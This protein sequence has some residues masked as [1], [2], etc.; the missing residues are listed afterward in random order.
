MNQTIAIVV[1]VILL[2][3]G[4]EQYGEHRIQ[5]KW[6][7]DKAARAAVTERDKQENAKNLADLK[8][9][10]EKEKKDAESEAGRRAVA[11]YLRDYGLLPSS[12]PVRIGDSHQADIPQRADTTSGE[13]GLA[14]RITE[15]AGRCIDDARKVE[16]CAEWAARENLPVE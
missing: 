7:E 11:K 5:V 1:A 4:V 8:E 13:S 12:I 2:L 10:F 15:L 3:I 14:E 6:N 9:Q 16:L